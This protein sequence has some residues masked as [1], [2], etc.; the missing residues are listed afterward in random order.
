MKFCTT[1]SGTQYKCEAWSPHPPVCNCPEKT[2]RTPHVTEAAAAASH[3]WCCIH[4]KAKRRERRLHCIR[5]IAS[6][7][8]R[9]RERGFHRGGEREGHKAEERGLHCREERGFHREGE[10]VTRR[11]RGEGVTRRRGEWRLM[12]ARLAL[13]CC[14]NSTCRPPA[15]G[16]INNDNAT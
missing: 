6:V 13:A 3:N 10:R 12:A 1:L 4:H 15:L 11:R 14:C 8:R 7:T 16:R 9:R 5:H 2:G